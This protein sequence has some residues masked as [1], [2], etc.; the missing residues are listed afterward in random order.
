MTGLYSKKLRCR[1]VY[2]LC[3][4]EGLKYSECADR[5][6]ISVKTGKNQMAIAIRKLRGKIVRYKFARVLPLFDS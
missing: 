4:F 2:I 5:L 1:T 6:G 3:W